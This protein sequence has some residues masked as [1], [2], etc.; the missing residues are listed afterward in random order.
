MVKPFSVAEGGIQRH[1]KKLSAQELGIAKVS[2]FIEWLSFHPILAAADGSTVAELN[3][4]SHKMIIFAHHH[5]VLDRVQEFI[6][7]KGVGFVRIDKNTL[8]CDRQSA[9][10]SFQSSKE[11]K[12]AMIGIK[13]GYAGLNL[14]AAQSVV[15]LELPNAPTELLQA[16]DRAHRR[17]Q[18]NAVNIYIFCAKD[19]CD[20]FRWKRLNKSLQRVSSTT[21]GKYDA[22]PE[23]AVDSID[24]LDS[25]AN[26]DRRLYGGLS[27]SISVCEE[28]DH[29]VQN[30]SV[31]DSVDDKEGLEGILDL[32]PDDVLGSSSSILPVSLRF[33]VS[34]YT[35]RIHLCMCILGTDSRPRPLSENFQPDEITDD[36]DAKEASPFI[37]S[38]PKCLEVIL[39]FIH[40]WKN[41]RPFDR[42][43]LLG[44]PLQL[45]LS[46]E[47]L[48][49]YESANH[50][51]RGLLSG[52]SKRRTTPFYDISL[53]PP[54]DATWKEVHLFGSCGKRNRTYIQAWTMMDEPLCKL[55][56]NPCMGINAKKPE[57]FEDL[58]CK[59]TCYEEYR[60][61]TSNR[62]LRQ[63]LFEIER[64]ICKVCKLDCHKLVKHLT[65]LSNA[66]REQYVKK[67]APNLAKHKK[68]LDKL[69]SDP[70][71]GNAWHADHLIPVY[72]GGG[73]CKVENMRTLCV[74]CH[75]DVTAAQCAERR[76]ARK[77]LK[78][79][80]MNMKNNCRTLQRCSST[81]QG[82]STST[83]DDD[84]LLLN[85]PGSAYSEMKQVSSGNTEP[86]SSSQNH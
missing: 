30:S 34:Q 53:P 47:L 82:C 79:I 27:S 33:A 11:V 78:N 60:S 77:Q 26:A 84:D 35:G 1:L 56:Q 59:L 69:V 31:N 17:G 64:G 42:R 76:L 74:A 4:S 48:C 19:T 28:G 24:C 43:K 10:Q 9:V 5:K 66:N 55:C 71:E 54:S 13:V 86:E 49:L 85:I 37:K 57:Y 51:Y 36:P 6:S 14:S 40:E 25:T 58:F 83:T 63:E 15:F 62:F 32:K 67:V 16:E 41:L 23:I 22:V 38:N 46:T 50:D 75:A 73:E 20:A 44:K 3:L 29:S 2:S 68:L 39:T 80:L 81:D 12:V 61:R 21:D 8:D 70:T 7:Q 45:P 72:Q 18:T 52:G 65:P